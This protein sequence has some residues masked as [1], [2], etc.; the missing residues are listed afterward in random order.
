MLGTPKLKFCMLLCFILSVFFYPSLTGTNSILPIPKKAIAQSMS[1]ATTFGSPGQPST[2]SPSTSSSLPA[3]SLNTS[4]IQPPPPPQSPSFAPSQS[5][6]ARATYGFQVYQNPILGLKVQYPSNWLLKERPY[7]ATGN[8]TIALFVSPTQ[9]AQTTVGASQAGQDNFIPYADIF[10]F[11]SNN[12][13]S[14]NQIMNETINNLSNATISQ[15]KPITLSNGKAARLV[16]YSIK[17][18]DRYLF[19]RI[20]VWTESGDKVFVIS[21]TSEPQTYL[22]YIPVMQ[23]MVQSL[24][25]TS[26]PN[27]ELNKP[28]GIR[29][30]SLQQRAD[31]DSNRQMNSENNNAPSSSVVPWLP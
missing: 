24:Q 29:D 27:T 12:N 25:V 16:E 28:V 14:L 7:N 20:Q 8:S 1:G 15:S 21:Y 13:T 10:V 26:P 22:N 19:D 18:A 2:P 31:A 4:A 6:T 30:S 9:P 3:S 17:I 23:K 5:L 11:H